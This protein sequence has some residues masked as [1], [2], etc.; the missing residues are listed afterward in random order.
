LPKVR[1]NNSSW[2]IFGENFRGKENIRMIFSLNEILREQNFT[3]F[4]L[5]SRKGKKRKKSKKKH[6]CFSPHPS[7]GC[8]DGMM[9]GW[10]C[11][12]DGEIR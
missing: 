9:V 10:G 11:W 7:D 8:V 1:E 2:K 5:I 3:K 6:F 4:R 12:M